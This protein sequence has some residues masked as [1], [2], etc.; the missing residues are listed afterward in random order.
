MAVFLQTVHVCQNP[1]PSTVRSLSVV[2]RSAKSRLP[3]Y[4]AEQNTT[5]IFR[6]NLS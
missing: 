4:I 1:V 3:R 6:M 5:P 2:F